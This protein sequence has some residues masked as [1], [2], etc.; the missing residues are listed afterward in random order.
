M[1]HMCAQN[2]IQTSV[3]QN[4]T[5]RQGQKESYFCEQKRTRQKNLIQKSTYNLF[6]LLKENSPKVGSILENITDIFTHVNGKYGRIF[7]RKL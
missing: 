5:R 6:N 3:M 1:Q 2:K 7:F 4:F